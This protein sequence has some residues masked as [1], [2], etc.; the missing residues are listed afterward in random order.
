MRFV[1]EPHFGIDKENPHTEKY[2]EYRCSTKA[3]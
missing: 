2:L 3:T 1:P